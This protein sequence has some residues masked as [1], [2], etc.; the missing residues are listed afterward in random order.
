M[1]ATSYKMSHVLPT[2]EEEMQDL[3]DHYQFVTFGEEQP[4]VR[5][6]HFKIFLFGNCLT[7]LYT[8]KTNITALHKAL[9][10]FSQQTN[11]A[12]TFREVAE[13]P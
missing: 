13:L 2:L 8:D 4:Q 1:T 10:L 9:E 6:E 12:Y 3:F 11:I 7:V 5:L